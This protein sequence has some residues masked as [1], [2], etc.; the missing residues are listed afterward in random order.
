MNIYWFGQASYLIKTANGKRL[1]IDP[2]GEGMGYTPFKGSVNLVTISHDHFDHNFTGFI[3]NSP[4][5]INTPGEHTVDFCEITGIKSFHDK[6]KGSERGNNIIF[7]YVIDNI[8]LC[9]LGDLGHDLDENT[10]NEIGTVDVLFVPVGEV[11]T[12]DVKSAVNVVKKINP[13]YIIPMHYRT[14]SL[15]I[16]LEGVDKFLMEMKD[17]ETEN[18]SIFS[19]DKNDLNNKPKIIL[20]DI[21]S[22]EYNK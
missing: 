8:T 14:K 12:L 11:Y 4:I 10:I 17:Y 6:T 16:P 1:L 20:I 7:K 22:N 2:F 15:N 9:H 18:V 13:K 3:E 5:I 19:V 21:C